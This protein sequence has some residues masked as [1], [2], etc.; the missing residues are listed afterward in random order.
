ML[1]Q[2]NFCEGKKWKKYGKKLRA[3]HFMRSV[4]FGRVKRL[5]RYLEFAWRGVPK[6]RVYLKEKILSGATDAIGYKHLRLIPDEGKR[7]VL[8]KVHQLVWKAFHPEYDRK[9]C[10]RT[11]I[12]HHKD[13]NKQNN[14][15]E[16]L[17]LISSAAH[18]KEHQKAY[19]QQHP[20]RNQK[21]GI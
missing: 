21:T 12:I 4:T 14:C 5:S 2:F 16:N 15:L 17:E 11:N 13:H 6:K 19:W 8:W 7:A 3:I 18:R 1:K 20:N 10:G 9:Q